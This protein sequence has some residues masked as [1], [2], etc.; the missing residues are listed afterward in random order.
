LNEHHENIP[1]A[2]GLTDAEFRQRER[3]LLVQF[4]A[5]VITTEELPDGYAF[6]IPGGTD[7]IM[8]TAALIAAERQCCRFLK[9]ELIAP[10]N[11]EPVTLRVTGPPGTKDFLKTTLCNSAVTI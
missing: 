5:T 10:S 8:A 1:V 2:C 3:T 9:F 4:R 11:T 7:V 6:R